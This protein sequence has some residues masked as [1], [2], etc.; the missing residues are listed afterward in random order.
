VPNSVDKALPVVAIYGPNA[1]GKSN[2]FEAV[3]FAWL[4]VR[5]SHQR[6]LPDDPIPRNPFLLDRASRRRPSQIVIDFVAEG[7]RYQYG[8]RWT[9]REFEKEW[10]NAYPVANRSR[11]IYMRSAGP[12]IEFGPSFTGPRRTLE[13]VVRANS[14]LLSAAAANNHPFLTPIYQWFS[15]NFHVAF[16]DN[17]FSRLESTLHKFEHH[18]EQRPALLDLLAFADFDIVDVRVKRQLRKA[19]DGRPSD[20]IPANGNDDADDVSEDVEVNVIHDVGKSRRKLALALESSGTR[21]WLELIGPAFD[22]LQ[23]GY[24]LIVDELDARLHP[25]LTGHLVKLFQDPAT[26]PHG[27]QLLFNTHDVSLLGPNAPARLRRDQVW[28]TERSNRR[29]TILY[30]LTDY[31]IRDGLDNV[32]RSYMRGRYGAIPEIMES[33]TRDFLDVEVVDDSAPSPS[34]DHGRKSTAE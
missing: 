4:A 15:R 19:D 8:F 16:A 28:L 33:A 30:P 25:V 17:A 31:R 23:Y 29:N 7:V 26:N 20:A 10:L 3:Y 21:A 18:P 5:F 9:E 32:E 34:A 11:A 2:L 12:E 13:G 1:S 24:L 6:W 27:A 22:A 14:L